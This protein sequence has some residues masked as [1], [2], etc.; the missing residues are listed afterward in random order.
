MRHYLFAYGTLKR[1]FR[2]DHYL[3]YS[4][5][6]G[7]AI[8]RESYFE[9]VE[10][11]HDAHSGLTYPAVRTTGGCRIVGEVYEID[12]DTL[13]K[14]DVLEREG[15]DYYRQMVDLDT[16]LSAWTYLDMD[17]ESIP[18]MPP[19]NIEI[20]GREVEYMAAASNRR[21]AGSI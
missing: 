12:N 8:T 13:E 11:A 5:Y 17:D 21:P 14:L 20:R 3:R 1:G 9:M 7:P 2:N 10:Y 6:I 15:K 19:P 18:L 16:G 4:R